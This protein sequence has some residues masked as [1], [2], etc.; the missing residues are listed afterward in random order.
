M[1]DGIFPFDIGPLNPTGGDLIVG[2]VTFAI[3]YLVLAGRLLPR[4]ARIIAER[5]RRT[6]GVMDGAEAVRTEAEEIRAQREAIL[7]EA[8]HE[9]ARTRQRAHEE[10][11]ELIAAARAEGIRERDRILVEGA[12]AI[13]AERIVAEEQLR[14][15]VDA[16]GSALA[17]RIVGEPLPG[18]EEVRRR[19]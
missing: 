10:G 16:W 19:D 7:A 12:A 13:E 1:N 18:A 5:E 6:R 3:T 11:T 15:D 4:A 17:E 9:A 14:L 2:F 8:R